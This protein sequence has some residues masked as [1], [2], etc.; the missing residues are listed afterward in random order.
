MLRAEPLARLEDGPGRRLSPCA[1]SGSCGGC[2]YQE[3]DY[4]A[5]LRLKAEVLRE[6]LARGGAPFDGEIE[7]LGSPESGWRMRASLHCAVGAGG[8]AIGFHRE[9]SHEIVAFDPCGQ[10]SAR[11]NAA[12]G[13][14]RNVLGSRA[15]LAA[16]IDR[17][18][19]AESADS[20]VL[21]AALEG[22]SLHPGDAP[23]LASALREIPELTGAGFM[24]G[25]KVRSRFL[26][27]FGDAFVHASVL[28][29]VL[30]AHVRSFFQSNRF[31]Y[32]D[33]ARTV[34][35]W[36]PPGG[37]VL[38]LYC[39][40]GLFAIPLAVRERE[41]RFF[42]VEISE[43][44]VRDAQANA[45][46]LPSVRFERSDV[47][48]ALRHRPREAHERVVLD[49][50]RTGAGPEVV[51]A[52]ASRQP[53]ALVYVSCDPPTLGRDL[54]HFARAG[55][56]PDRLKAFDMFPDTFHVE[57]VARLVPA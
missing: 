54:A 44:A 1:F 42:G 7:I 43:S 12:V 36:V 8:V 33:L 30:R 52:I 4:S 20:R 34:V 3:L 26:P 9:A 48:S 31:L 39:G 53:D 37:P 14:L 29:R 55:Y 6:S 46:G 19:L 24:T 56:R 25:G 16:R 22:E 45:H 51:A 49:P 21:V 35:D 38:D 5:Q 28:G 15:S 40:V 57:A 10:L 32:E 50:P 41:N 11:A 13:G 23:G 17:I 18:D 2:A 27:L 47:A